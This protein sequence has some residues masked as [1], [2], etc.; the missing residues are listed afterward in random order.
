ME[1]KRKNERIVKK[2]VRI[3]ERKVKD[4]QNVGRKT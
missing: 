2:V 1:I 3:Q 4:K